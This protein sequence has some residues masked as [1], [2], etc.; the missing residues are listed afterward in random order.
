MN[1]LESIF[2]EM[3]NAAEQDIDNA[4]SWWIMKATN[5]HVL[6]SSVYKKYFILKKYIAE[7]K[8]KH[9][10]DTQMTSAKAKALVEALPEYWQAEELKNQ[11][12]YVD[13]LIMLAKKMA[14]M[15]NDELKGY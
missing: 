12:K 9:L 4:P 11:K 7:E 15:T 1:T 8:V 13:D 6:F 14:S 3:E 10:K 2:K 5:L